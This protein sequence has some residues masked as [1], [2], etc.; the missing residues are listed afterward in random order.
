[1]PLIKG[2]IVN[3]EKS[4]DTHLY[5]YRIVLDEPV[6]DPGDEVLPM[7]STA[8]VEIPIG[9][10]VSVDV[11][12]PKSLGQRAYEAA[13][14]VLAQAGVR[15]EWSALPPEAKQFFEGGVAA[16]VEDK[17]EAEAPEASIKK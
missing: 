17:L 13:A 15:K 9:T 6:Y 4:P 1:M 11:P 8:T 14:P 3:R 7:H 10:A 2:K 5:A 16:A 12:E